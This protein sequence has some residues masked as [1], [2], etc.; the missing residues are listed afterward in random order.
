MIVLAFHKMKVPK[1]WKERKKEMPLTVTIKEYN[2]QSANNKLLKRSK[3]FKLCVGEESFSS[4][5]SES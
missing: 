2:L 4:I 1:L 5:E 3:R